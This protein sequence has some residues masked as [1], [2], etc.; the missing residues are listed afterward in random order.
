[1]INRAN[2]FAVIATVLLPRRV[3]LFAPNR[4]ALTVTARNAGR[5]NQHGSV[6]L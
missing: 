3:E 2:S 6:F 5:P 1:M 4:L